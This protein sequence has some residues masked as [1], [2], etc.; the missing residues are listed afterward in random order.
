LSSRVPLRAMA[1]RSPPTESRP[2]QQ[3][4]I[5]SS[6]ISVSFALRINAS[7]N[8]TL[9]R[10]RIFLITGIEGCLTQCEVR[11]ARAC[12]CVELEGGKASRIG[13]SDDGSID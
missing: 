12:K 9:A 8:Q 5:W 6:C 4:L 10:V 1:W 7:D 2:R 3:A 13:S 11:R